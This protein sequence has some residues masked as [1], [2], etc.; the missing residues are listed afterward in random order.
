MDE[1]ENNLRRIRQA[2]DA[3]ITRDSNPSK[4]V[5]LGVVAT[6]PE[7]IKEKG[8]YSSTSHEGENSGPTAESEIASD[9][10]TD[11][12]E[13]SDRNT[14]RKEGLADDDESLDGAGAEELKANELRPADDGG[15]V[16]HLPDHSFV[17]SGSR[18]HDEVSVEDPP[19][20]DSIAPDGRE[21][22]NAD[23]SRLESADH[24][25]VDASKAE[26]D[27]AASG[28]EESV[29]TIAPDAALPDSSSSEG[30]SENNIDSRE[31]TVVKSSI[32]SRFKKWVGFK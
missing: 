21:D 19:S 16:I 8:T 11:Y 20:E 26:P 31:L 2:V 10:T 18:S 5:S 17:E 29:V 3:R 25:R 28:A 1:L 32:W 15:G 30:A 9:K 4:L 27:Q 6:G 14:N 12:A 7:V 24:E 23:T 22:S 13:K